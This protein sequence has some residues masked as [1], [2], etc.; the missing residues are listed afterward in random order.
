MSWRGG[1]RRIGVRAETVRYSNLRPNLSDIYLDIGL[2][3]SYI[4]NIAKTGLV[5]WEF[6]QLGP[7][8]EL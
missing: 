3:A 4:R 6:S 8:V 1:Y 7:G 5:L 2:N